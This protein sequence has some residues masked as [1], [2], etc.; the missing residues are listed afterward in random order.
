MGRGG[1]DGRVVTVVP[2][3]IT[4]FDVSSVV[5]P[6]KSSMMVAHCKEVVEGGVRVVGL[7]DILGEVES[8]Q[9]KFHQLV[10]L[11]SPVLV[12]LEAFQ[13]DD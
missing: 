8:L 1:R 13:V 4:C 10:N 2:L 12:V 9:R 3:A 6:S 5:S 7:D 11:F